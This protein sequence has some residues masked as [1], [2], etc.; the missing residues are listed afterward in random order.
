MED[1]SSDGST[2]SRSS[3]LLPPTRSG[4]A[5]PGAVNDSTSTTSTPPSTGS[6]SEQ[7]TPQ[8]PLDQASASYLPSV[9]LISGERGLG[10]GSVDDAGTLA[11]A[12]AHRV[13][14]GRRERR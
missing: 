1:L 12:G 13:V 5:A 9:V 14:G 8:R 4:S 3:C 2:S 6:N 7:H 11:G 10:I